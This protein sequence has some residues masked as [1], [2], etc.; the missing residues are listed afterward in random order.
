MLA[1]YSVFSTNFSKASEATGTRVQTSQ[2]RLKGS[3]VIRDYHS[4]R[5]PFK[6]NDAEKRSGAA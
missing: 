1:Q 4:A 6:P 3:N 5:C 2:W